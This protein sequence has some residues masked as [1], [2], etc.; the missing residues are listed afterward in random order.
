MSRLKSPPDNDDD[1][2]AVKTLVDSTGMS[3][4]I[5]TNTIEQ[6]N[7]EQTQP[8]PKSDEI[9]RSMIYAMSET[10]IAGETVQIVAS[11]PLLGPEVELKEEIPGEAP[12]GNDLINVEEG[13]TM[14]WDEFERIAE[15][16]R[17]GKHWDKEG[18]L[19]DSLAEF[20]QGRP[21][22]NGELIKMIYG[23]EFDDDMTLSD[24]VHYWHCKPPSTETK[25]FLPAPSARD[26]TS[27]SSD[28]PSKLIVPG[29][30]SPGPRRPR[31][32]MEGGHITSQAGS[33]SLPT[34]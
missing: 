22:T 25:L 2:D 18:V 32:L 27:T 20:L 30:I 11:Q 4:I 33:I 9:Q 10:K 29:K 1:D 12:A 23:Y 13:L 7:Q 24:I 6:P 34:Q 5:E 3:E 28:P 15:E 19:V 14:T 16:R 31:V 17:Q 8:L 21:P 26:A